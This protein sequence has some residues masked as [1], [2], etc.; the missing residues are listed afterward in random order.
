[1]Y[2]W[3]RH[4]RLVASLVAEPAVR[5]SIGIGL[6]VAVGAV[7]GAVGVTVAGFAALE[8]ARRRGLLFGGAHR[9]GAVGEA[10]VGPDA[11]AHSVRSLV[12]TA[13]GFLLLIMVQNQDLLIANRILSP[14]DAGR[15]AVL[16]TIGGLAAFATMTVPLV[17]LPRSAGGERNAL[18]AA[19][20]A[21]LVLG[22][23]ALAVVSIAPGPLVIH[24]FGARYESV[25]RLVFPYVLAMA[26]LGLAR[27]FAAQRCATGAARSTAVL[28]F[29]AAAV[30]VILIVRYSHTPR[31]VALST[32]TATS[33]LAGTL[34]AAV[35]LD[36]PGIRRR[37]HAIVHALTRPIPLLVGGA[38]VVGLAIRLAVPR[39]LWLDEVT[40][41]FQARMGYGAMINNLRTTDV[42]PPLYF[43]VLWVAIRWLHSSGEMAVRI[44][45]I[46]PGALVVPMLY[47]L[48][49]EAYDRR[50]GVIAAVVGSVAPLMVW[51]SQEARM[52]ALLMLFGV[53][54]MWAQVR[55]LK[56]G[57]TFPWVVYALASAAMVWTQ[58]FGLW[59][60]LAQQL[61]FLVVIWK[62]HHD[63]EPAKR[64]TL[65][66]GLSLVAILAIVCPL[67]PFAYHQFVLNQTAG[68][69]F[70]GP[71][72][73][74]TAA[75]LTG[76]HVGVYS[77][78]AN[79]IWAVWGYHSTS[80]MALLGALWPLGMLLALV[81]LGSRRQPVTTLMVL[82]VVIPVVGMLGLGLV[83]AN[84]FDV[85]YLSTIVPVLFVLIARGLSGFV[86]S[87]KLI[88]VGLALLVVLMLGALA[89]QQLNG[90]NPRLYDFRSALQTIDA[91]A[92]PGDLVLYAPA[93]IN[94]VVK[95]YSPHLHAVS[96]S[97]DVPLAIKQS[98]EAHRIFVVS[99]P[100]LINSKA[101]DGTLS[102]TLAVLNE[103]DRL[104]S[105]QKLS[106]VDLWVYR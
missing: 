41:V 84:L 67:V 61:I 76:N 95:Y 71:S 29:L 70:G 65:G 104:I 106:N 40:S 53:I 32:L 51:Y 74:G 5:L 90:Q 38:S 14:T 6:V 39:G 62:R 15:F 58:Y 73:V 105:H 24:L 88:R 60:V 46:I 59:Q 99:S 78:L 42:H 13:V 103:H 27:V 31:A 81:V 94:Q 20:V 4:S 37:T 57:G 9:R 92:R 96:I 101:G 12:W 8:I 18:G 34:G 48:G 100:P 72:N 49:K 1:L 56:R 2:G 52:Y 10:T 64:L 82:A 54:A 21:A 30:Q 17:L 47:V 85:R 98:A 89:D 3:H 77:V 69:G 50:T 66:W 26:L 7:G 93:D 91:Q 55:V 75:S 83:K 79:L 43:S 36:L 35:T 63:G 86:K 23:G 102:S 68:R 45:S 87:E 25:A 19:V 22:G 28:V 11:D 80:A 97:S 16:S 44:P 33:A